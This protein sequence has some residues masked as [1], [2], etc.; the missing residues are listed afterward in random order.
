MIMERN[1]NHPWRQKTNTTTQNRSQ[2]TS[3]YARNVKGKIENS[4]V[5]T[6]IIFITQ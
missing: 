3:M 6:N 4:K 1:S 5:A 2:K